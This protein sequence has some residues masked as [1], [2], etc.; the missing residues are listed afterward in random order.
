MEIEAVYMDVDDG[1]LRTVPVAVTGAYTHMEEEGNNKIRRSCEAICFYLDKAGNLVYVES[2]LA[3]EEYGHFLGFVP[4]GSD[5]EVL[6][7]EAAG[8]PE[9]AFEVRDHLPQT[10]KAN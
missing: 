5:P 6:R 10:L 9:D 4:D 3:S 1:T 7:P 8:L 2:I